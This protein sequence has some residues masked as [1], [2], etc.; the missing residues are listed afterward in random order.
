MGIQG[1]MFNYIGNSSLS[2]VTLEPI[3]ICRHTYKVFKGKGNVPGAQYPLI[4]ECSF[5]HIWT[6]RKYIG[7]LGPLGADSKVV[8][9]C[10]LQVQERILMLAES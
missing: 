8:N 4:Q 5:N 6:P 9:I 1:Y 2:T 3:E 10:K 7:P